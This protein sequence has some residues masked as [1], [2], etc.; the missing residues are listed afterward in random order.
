MRSSAILL[1]AAAGAALLAVPAA[2]V[3]ERRGAAPVS[4]GER[5]FQKCYSCHALSDTDEGAPG[6]SLKGIVDR[7]VASWP[8]YD[9]SVVGQFE[10][11]PANLCQP[12][13]MG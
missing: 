5:A 9:Y 3:A 1:M 6:P 2:T 13:Y 8:R 11:S 4:A 12:R 10:I 7:P